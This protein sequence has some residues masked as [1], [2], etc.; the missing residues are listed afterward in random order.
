MGITDKPLEIIVERAQKL[1]E[2]SLKRRKIVDEAVIHILIR[3]SCIVDG[4]RF[5][6]PLEVFVNDIKKP[7]SINLGA[8][9]RFNELDLWPLVGIDSE[10]VRPV[11]VHLV[12][13]DGAENYFKVGQSSKMRLE[14]AFTR[15]EIEKSGKDFSD[16]ALRGPAVPPHI[17]RVTIKPRRAGWFGSRKAIDIPKEWKME[18][19]TEARGVLGDP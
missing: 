19:Q 12:P 5:A 17:V 13:T 8:G 14:K 4:V 11:D 6:P 18:D 3:V 9:K 2:E 10:G 7:E 15:A 1:Y 16:P